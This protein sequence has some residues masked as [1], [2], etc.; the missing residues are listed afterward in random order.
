MRLQTKGYVS[1]NIGGHPSQAQ[2]DSVLCTQ[3]QGVQWQSPTKKGVPLEGGI[4]PGALTTKNLSI[5]DFRISPCP[6]ETRTAGF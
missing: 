4:D 5:C 3:A 1:A 6:P 2:S